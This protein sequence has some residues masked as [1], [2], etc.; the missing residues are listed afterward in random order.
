MESL[1][2]NR[3]LLYSLAGAG[4]FVVMLALGKIIKLST[5]SESASIIL[6][7]Q[8]GCRSSVISLALWTSLMSLDP[9][10]FRLE[11]FKSFKQHS[12]SIEQ[13]S[14]LSRLSRFPLS[15]WQVSKI[16]IGKS[17]SGAGYRCGS[18]IFLGQNSIVYRR[19]G[20]TQH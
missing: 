4:G 15:S 2:D 8:A 9:F 1:F 19:G 20:E 3:P 16:V 18:S 6:I 17:L 12:I 14:K 10:S 11:I 13:F 7:F 5:D